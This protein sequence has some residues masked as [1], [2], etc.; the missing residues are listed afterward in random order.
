[1]VVVLVML[2]KKY[3]LLSASCGHL[4]GAFVNKIQVRAFGTPIHATATAQRFVYTVSIHSMSFIPSMQHIDT[5]TA[6]HSIISTS[7]VLW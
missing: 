5:Y 6:A 7:R 3:W 4:A 1:V 2:R